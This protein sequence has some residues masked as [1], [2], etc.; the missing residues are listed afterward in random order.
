MAYSLIVADSDGFNPQV[1]A[2]PAKQPLLSPS[3]SPDGRKIVYVSFES[4]NSNIY[5]Q[6]ITTGLRQLVESHKGINGAPAWS[7]DG[8]KLAVALS[9]SG[10]LNIYAPD[11]ASRQDTRI[12]TDNLSI[13]TEPVW[14]PSGESIYFT[15]DRS[16]RRRSTRYL[17]AVALPRA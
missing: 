5:V 4:G 10:D 14:A 12:T 15:S 1:A 2:G 11:M 13:N 3:W 8:R 9:F 17:P 16:A 7:P 6:D